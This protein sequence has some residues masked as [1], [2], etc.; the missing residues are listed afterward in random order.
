MLNFEETIQII[1][2]VLGIA[3]ALYYIPFLLRKGW[4]DAENRT[5]KVCDVCFKDISKF[6]KWVKENEKHN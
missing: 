1:L 6:D 4:N 3:T 5:K 2:K